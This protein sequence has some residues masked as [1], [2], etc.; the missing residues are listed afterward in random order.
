ME[1]VSLSSRKSKHLD[2]FLLLYLKLI[3]F[4][5]KKIFY[6]KFRKLIA[7]YQT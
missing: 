3:S 6:A 7:Y 4:D 1:V 2:N 5:F